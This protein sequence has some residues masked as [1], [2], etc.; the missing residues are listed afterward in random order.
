VNRLVRYLRA[1]P[2]GASAELSD[3]ELLAR[4][5]R[6]RDGAAFAALVARHGGAVWAACARLLDREEDAEDAFQAVFLT[7][8]RKAVS[9][10]D[11]LPAFLHGVARRVAANARRDARRRSATEN[12]AR[13]PEA[14][15]PNVSWHEGLALLDEE[16]ARLPDRYRAVLVACCLEGRSRD[17]AARHLGWTVNRVKG[18]LERGR[19]LLRQRLA[20]RGFDLGAV[21]L[22]AT[23][24][25]SVGAV[26]AVSVEMALRWAQGQGAV[27]GASSAAVAL[28]ERVMSAMFVQKLKA[29][30]AVLVVAAVAVGGALTHRAAEGTEPVPK[31]EKGAPDPFAPQPKTEAP[32]NPFNPA[33]NGGNPFAPGTGFDPGF[34]NKFPA[35]E[36]QPKLPS[37]PD[38]P[39]PKM[40]RE[41]GNRF[42]VEVIGRTDGVCSGTELYFY[43]SDL[44]TAAVHAGLVKA[45]EKA[46]ITVT[47]V[48]CP[49]SSEGSTRNGVKSLPWVEARPTDTALLLQRIPGRVVVNQYDAL[50]IEEAI[51][52]TGQ[53]VKVAFEVASVEVDERIQEPGPTD[54]RIVTFNPKSALKTGVFRVYLIH[55]AV[56]PVFKL[57]LVKSK[58]GQG[59]DYFRGKTVRVTGTVERVDHPVDPTVYR[60]LVSDIGNLE[61]IK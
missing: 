19:E 29:V 17:E 33:P 40:L 55:T 39:N 35:G 34:G 18:L 3:R 59:V 42:D 56:A 1:I 28:S 38:A 24:A 16:L 36:P 53:Q 37:A 13:V 60:I 15:T 4:F 14:R 22:A 44:G 30:A 46:V 58:S 6:E 54:W 27:G 50:T 8:A 32:P 61:V 2:A 49:K 43:D 47:V 9:V 51:A 25:N 45:N 31:T 7:L 52:K 10:G 5:T 12:A 23:V 20:R 11:C 48:K 57:G 21:L 41:P 26:P